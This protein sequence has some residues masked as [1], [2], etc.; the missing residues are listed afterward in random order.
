MGNPQSSDYG[1]SAFNLNRENISFNF[2]VNCLV[3]QCGKTD[4]S[5]QKAKKKFN[6][7]NKLKEFVAQSQKIIL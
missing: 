5:F 4:F 6:R 3:F 1:T 2:P 7:V